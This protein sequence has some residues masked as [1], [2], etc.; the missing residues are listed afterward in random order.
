MFIL[1]LIFLFFYF[2]RIECFENESMTTIMKKAKYE[3][4]NNSTH[5]IASKNQNYTITRNFEI[6]YTS[7]PNDIYKINDKNGYIVTIGKSTN[8]LSMSGNFGLDV[9]TIDYNRGKKRININIG[10]NKKIITGYGSF[11]NEVT[12]PWN[13]LLPIVY[14]EGGS[15]IAIMDG[16]SNIVDI[17]VSNKYSQYLPLFFEVYILMKEYVK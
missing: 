7:N 2:T 6:I 17:T 16:S 11:Q 13:T 1:F 4:K 10:Y 15:I 8:T 9:F 14:T 3:L 12:E 5:Y